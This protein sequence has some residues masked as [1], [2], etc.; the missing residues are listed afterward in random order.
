MC[1]NHCSPDNVNKN[2]KQQ[3]VKMDPEG[4]QILELARYR[5]KNN[6]IFMFK[7][8][9]DKFEKLGR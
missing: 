5:L 3:E 2:K 1:E 9:K 8:V 4:Y 6:Y 7:Q